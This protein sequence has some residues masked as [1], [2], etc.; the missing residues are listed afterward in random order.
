MLDIDHSKELFN[1]ENIKYNS[2]MHEV[3]TYLHRAKQNFY[4]CLVFLLGLYS[5]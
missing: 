5:R 3:L 1:R 2:N 4:L